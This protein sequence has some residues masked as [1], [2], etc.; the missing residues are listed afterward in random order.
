M[1]EKDELEKVLNV[2]RNA[3]EQIKS[4][5]W[6]ASDDEIGMGGGTEIGLTFIEKIEIDQF[7]KIHGPA[8]TTQR[9]LDIAVPKAQ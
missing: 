6:K 7:A 2:F 8:K 4:A 9:I 3:S 1:V 5:L